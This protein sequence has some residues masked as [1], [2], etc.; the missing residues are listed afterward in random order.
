MSS[1]NDVLKQKF[2]GFSYIPGE[3]LLDALKSVPDQP[4]SSWFKNVSQ[5]LVTI[6]CCKMKPDELISLIR[7]YD[8]N[9]KKKAQG[10]TSATVCSST[11]AAPLS[12]VLS[13]V[14]KSVDSSSNSESV[15]CAGTQLVAYP[16]IIC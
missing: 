1:Q 15:C 9:D 16:G 6:N 12:G 11:P 5:I 4:K 7:S 2:E 8:K 13:L 14:N 3:T 10:D